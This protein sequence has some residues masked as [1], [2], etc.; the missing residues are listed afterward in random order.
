MP[1][2]N[3]SRASNLNQKQLQ[4]ITKNRW[5]G[6]ENSILRAFLDC[7]R[8]FLPSLTPPLCYYDY[9]YPCFWR[10]HFG[11]VRIIRA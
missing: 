5:F 10:F 3:R 8:F 11:L 1:S 2:L 7:L 4:I 6:S 9:Y